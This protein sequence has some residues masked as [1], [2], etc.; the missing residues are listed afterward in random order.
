MFA[1][2]YETQ[3]VEIAQRSEDN[4]VVDVPKSNIKLRCVSLL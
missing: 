3:G 4:L 2:G 1:H